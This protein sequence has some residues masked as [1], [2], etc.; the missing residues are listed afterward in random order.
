LSEELT[1]R[2]HLQ[3][4]SDQ[5]AQRRQK[6][7]R[8]REV[9]RDPFHTTRFDRT[10]FAE[11]IHRGFDALEGQVVRVAGRIRALR[12]HGKAAFADLQDCSGRIQLLFRLNELGEAAYQEAAEFDLGDI[13]GATGRVLRTRTG[14]VTA[15]VTGFSLLAKALR[16]L[17]EKWH[18]LRDV[19]V[20]YRQRY[21]DL[22]VTEETRRLFEVRSKVISAIRRFLDARGF[23]EV[24]TPTM[25]A[26]AGGALARPFITHHNA[27]DTDFYLRVA[28][29][30]YLKRLVV[31]GMERVYEIGRVFRNEGVS[32]KHN[33]E[34]TLLEVYQAY[35]DYRQIMELTEQMVAQA[36]QDALGTTKISYQ[37]QEA[38]LAPP[39]RRI[40]LLE[41]IGE[42]TG[43]TPER[44]ES[45]AEARKVCAELNLPAGPDLHLSTMVNNIFEEFVQPTLVAPTFVSDYPT[46]IS[47]L[48]KAHADNPDLAE[49]FEAFILGTELVNAFSELNDPEEQRRRFEQQA[50]AR[51]AGDAEAHPMDQDFLRALEYGMPPTGGLGVGIDRL[52]MI[53]T[54]APSIRDVILFPHM[55]PQA[56]R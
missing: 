45:E 27:L 29:E 41:S 43:V 14:E 17:P 50:R 56:G 13:L 24:E 47:P 35:A 28:T 23:L 52:V 1:Q 9:G 53:L 6:L 40:S 26:V 55:R 32:T 46:L 16:P 22:I 38:D 54:D 10:H 5:V 44:L 8:L 2:D 33:P 11:D 39:W 19:E 30:L 31:G 21:L 7:A 34:Y 36:A 48:A 3:Q 51:E 20:R 25:Q 37:G 12:R 4:E 42:H 49:R 18:G 15:E